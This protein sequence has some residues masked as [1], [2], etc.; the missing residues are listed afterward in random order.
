MRAHRFAFWLFVFVSVDFGTPFVGGAFTFDASSSA[1]GVRVRYES[2]EARGGVPC[3][4]PSGR[5]EP[6]RKVGMAPSRIGQ[7]PR[8]TECW[9]VDRPRALALSEA[10]PARSEDH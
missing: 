8:S 5:I 9:M 2:G 10:P 4:P 7:S 6:N 3:L 1:E